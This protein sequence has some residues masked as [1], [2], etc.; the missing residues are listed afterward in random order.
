MK[1]TE[2]ALFALGTAALVGVAAYGIIRK[3]SK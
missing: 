2:K 3:K 1:K